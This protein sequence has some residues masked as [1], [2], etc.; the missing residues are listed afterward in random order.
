M[1]LYEGFLWGVAGG[2]FAELLGWFKLRHQA[3]DDLPIQMKTRYYWIVTAVMILAGGILVIA[4]LRSD[5]KVNAIMALNVGA[6]A[7]LILGALVSQS[8]PISPGRID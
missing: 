8:P 3:A 6:S 2:I 7:P 5:V 4:Y 1:G